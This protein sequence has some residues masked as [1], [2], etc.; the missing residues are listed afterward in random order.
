MSVQITKYPADDDARRS[1]DRRLRLLIVSHHFPSYAKPTHAIYNKQNFHALSARF[2]IKILVPVDWVSWLRYGKRA[3][4]G[5]SPLDV[6]YVPYFYVPKTLRRLAPTLM[7]LSIGTAFRRLLRWKPDAVLASWSFP[8]AVAVRRLLGK[9]NVPFFGQVHGSDVHLHCLVPSRRRQI[10]ATFNSAE[11][12]FAV[13]AD[14]RASLIDHGVEPERVV[15]VYNGVDDS[16][17][18]PVERA[19]ARSSLG[20][21]SASQVFLFVGNLKEPKGPFDLLEGFR[22]LAQRGRLSDSMLIYVGQGPGQ[23]RLTQLGAELEAEFPGL[24]V[25]VRGSVPHEQ[26]NQWMNAADFVCLPSHSEG[27]PNVVLEAMRCGIPVIAS[28]VGGIPEVLDARC[29]VMVPAKDVEAIADG[30]D[31]ARQSKWNRGE[32]RQYSARFQWGRNS[33]HIYRLISEFDKPKNLELET[34]TTPAERR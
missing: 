11:A 7:C 17:F 29:G 3:L 13:S 27:V 14:L 8:D 31:K 34:V 5:D 9:S 32:I 4:N 30:I 25:L 2:D 26:I 28:N 20:L 23:R 15:V 33:D 18:F 24:R 6:H 21:P 19:L 16:K 12:V 22:S 10:V 1:D